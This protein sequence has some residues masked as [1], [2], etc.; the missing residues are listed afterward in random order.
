[1]VSGWIRVMRKMGQRTMSNAFSASRTMTERHTDHEPSK[2]D[3]LYLRLHRGSEN[4]GAF[5]YGD[6][7]IQ[8]EIVVE[9]TYPQS[10]RF[11]KMCAEFGRHSVKCHLSRSITKGVSGLRNLSMTTV[12]WS[13]RKQCEL[14]I[15]SP[16]ASFSWGG[17][18]LSLILV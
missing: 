1:M 5:R 15:S 18:S 6:R 17:L 16:C 8:S 2:P 12:S 3:Q 11:G 9:D 7:S 13:R 4:A 14:Y 10:A